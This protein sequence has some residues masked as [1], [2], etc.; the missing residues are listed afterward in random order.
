MHAL[1]H[2]L[3]SL[4]F[5]FL[6]VTLAAQVTALINVAGVPC[7]VATQRTGKIKGGS[8]AR[9]G[10]F[11]WL[12]S[13]RT[14]GPSSGHYCGGA[15]IHKKFVLTAAHCVYRSQ[16]KRVSVVAGEHDL[17]A[18]NP[19]RQLLSV[20]EVIF[21][22]NFSKRYINDIALLELA[23]EAQWTKQVQPLCLPD[24]EADGVKELMD[25]TVAGWGKTDEL[26]NGGV[27]ARVLQKVVIRVLARNQCQQWYST[28]AGQQVQLFDSH[29]CAG[30]ENGEKDACQGD[31]GGPLLTT[32]DAAGRRTCVGVVSAGIGCGR[33][34]LPGLYTRVSR[35]IDWILDHMKA[36]GV[37][38]GV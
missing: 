6:F 23:T 18:K 14:S 17:D 5:V 33:P 13:I 1:H 35:Y 27:S 37:S 28:E 3:A 24:R 8:V 31:S 22:A 9:P 38:V 36:R 30:Y 2:A 29:L 12:V 15:L 11:P 20:K 4:P 26:A 32:P 25:L 34:H 7:G 19:Q 21:H 16:P 10:E